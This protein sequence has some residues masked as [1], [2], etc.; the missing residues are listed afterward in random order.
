MS[1]EELVSTFHPVVAAAAGEIGLSRVPGN[2]G[3]PLLVLA[4]SAFRDRRRSRKR[5]ATSTSSVLALVLAFLL[6]QVEFC[7]LCDRIC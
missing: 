3:V 4:C 2:F 6:L 5:E 1:P 7:S